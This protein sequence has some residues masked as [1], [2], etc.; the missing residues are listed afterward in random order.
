MTRRL[1]MMGLIL[2]AV[3]APCSGYAQQPAPGFFEDFNDGV[4]N[5]WNNDGTGAWSVTDWRYTAAAN[6]TL[7]VFYSHYRETY[8]NFVYAADV[9]KTAGN[10]KRAMGLVFRTDGTYNNGYVFHIN[11]NGYY[12]IFKRVNGRTQYLIRDWTYSP[13][14]NTGMNVWNRLEV[15]CSGPDLTFTINGQ[16]VQTITDSSFASGRV[17][18]KAFGSALKGDVVQFDNAELTPAGIP[19]GMHVSISRSVRAAGDYTG[20]GTY[21]DPCKTISDAISE[22]NANEASAPIHVE[23]GLYGQA[24]GESFPFYFYDGMQILCGG[25]SHS[26]IID[27]SGGTGMI[28]GGLNTAVTGCTIRGGSPAV[29]DGNW[30]VAYPMEIRNNIIDGGFCSGIELWADST[31]KGNRIRNIDAG[32]CN[33]AGIYISQSSPS[34]TGNVITNT[35]FGAGIYIY[36][37]GASVTD[38]KVVSNTTGIYFSDD[39]AGNMPVIN[40][41]IVSCNDDADL[42]VG[43]IYSNLDARNNSW[44]HVPPATGACFGGMDI[45]TWYGDLGSIDFSGAKLAPASC[46]KIIPN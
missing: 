22:L 40:N 27:I 10:V 31:V 30:S 33:T 3:I 15:D 34:V 38:N 37:G 11:A 4:A 8:D 25:P 21:L 14:I 26:T 43:Y 45:C 18:V 29:S 35:S 41:N 46:K 24:A 23:K 9:R 12:L 39:D 42:E 7:R 20:C 44:D 36:G 13:S 32:D 5:R 6:T 2:L 19:F 28:A 1:G 17:G 16:I